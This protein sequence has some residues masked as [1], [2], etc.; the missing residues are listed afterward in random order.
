MVV[1]IADFLWS[2]N[3]TA[4]ITYGNKCGY[5]RYAGHCVFRYFFS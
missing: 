2:Y 1:Q 3:Y 5:S 4:I